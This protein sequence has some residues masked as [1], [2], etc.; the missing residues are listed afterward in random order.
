MAEDTDRALRERVKELEC[1]YEVSRV[2]G[3]AGTGVDELVSALVRIIPGGFQYPDMAGARIRV[4]PILR[5]SPGFRG[6]GLL[7]SVAVPDSGGGEGRI[8][9]SYPPEITERDAKPFL[10]EEDQLLEKIASELALAA[11]RLRAAEET[12]RLETQLR[13]ADRLTTVGVLAAGIAHE[14]NEPLSTILG[15]AQ[16]VRRTPGIPPGAVRDVSRIV[17]SALHARE[18]IRR[19]L[20]FGRA[21][22]AAAEMCRLDAVV[23]SALDFLEPRC[24]AEGITV[25][26]EMEAGEAGI[27]AVPTEIRQVVVNLAVNAIQAMPGGGTLYVRTGVEGGWYRLEVED[28]G[29]GMPAHVLDRVFTPFF[30]TKEAG[31][32]T[33]LGLPVAHGIVTS[34][35]G[36]LSAASEAGKG[37][38]F[39]VRLPLAAAA[40]KGTG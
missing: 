20:G 31:R 24:K 15:F 38:R 30:T 18:V 9:V 29:V 22:P 25:R 27:T 4:G 2:L 40:E 23:G 26:R 32:G 21:A 3:K 1:L 11:G 33:G 37:S 13:H 36:T 12:A 19:L 8:Q 10:P 28:T 39:T 5:A 34:R 7:L 14:L 6:D 35:R 16:L 17:D